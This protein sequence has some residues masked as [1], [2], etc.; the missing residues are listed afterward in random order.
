MARARLI[1][2][3]AVCLLPIGFQEPFK[4]RIFFFCFVLPAILSMK[5]AYKPKKRQPCEEEA[6][7]RN[8]H[9]ESL[10]SKWT[11]EKTPKRLHGRKYII[12][13]FNDV[14]YVCKHLELTKRGEIV[15]T[16]IFSWI[17]TQATQYIH[18][19]TRKNPNEKKIKREKKHTQKKDTKNN[20]WNRQPQ[21]TYT[22][23]VA[24]ANKTF[25][26]QFNIAQQQIRFDIFG[27]IKSL[28]LWHFNVVIGC[29]FILCH[30]SPQLGR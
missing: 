13:Q 11:K 28:M 2:D 4:L 27:Q 9:T 8:T 20:E 24:T 16:I 19:N 29:V 25:Y 7:V 10:K 3:S 15:E 18:T 30:Q 17:H 21:Y 6:K 23:A 14:F 22:N 1:H 5:R 26:T 12:H